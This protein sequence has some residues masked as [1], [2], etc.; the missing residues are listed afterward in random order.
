MFY[1][2]RDGQGKVSGVFAN[3]QL[4]YAEEPLAN[5]DPE[6]IAFINPPPDPRTTAIDDSIKAQPLGA[7][8]PA[9]A[10]QVKAMTLA[11]QSAWYDANFNT[12]AELKAL[13][14]R[15]VLIVVRRIL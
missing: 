1:I 10:A 12:I 15:L 2:Q 8:Q 9:T 11:E 3:R 14:K 13:L 4:G 6:L 5:D 7:V